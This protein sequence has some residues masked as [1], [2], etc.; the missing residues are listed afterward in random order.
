MLFKM[1]MLLVGLIFIVATFGAIYLGYEKNT[2]EYN[3][4]NR[5]DL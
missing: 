5:K 4:R 1:A 2:E 3:N